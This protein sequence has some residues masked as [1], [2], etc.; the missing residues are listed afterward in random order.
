MTACQRLR[1]YNC[2]RKPE[3]NYFQPN[4]PSMNNVEG[5]CLDFLVFFVQKPPGDGD[6]Q[7]M[8][9]LTGGRDDKEHHNH[10]HPPS[11]DLYPEELGNGDSAGATNNNSHN[12]SIFRDT[13]GSSSGGGR[14]HPGGGGGGR[15]GLFAP[16]PQ[17]PSRSP[18]PALHGGS[19]ENSPAAAGG[20]SPMMRRQQ[21]GRSPSPI[22]GLMRRASFPANA[23]P[24]NFL[25]LRGG[26]HGSSR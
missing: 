8:R 7:T 20:A 23:R 10:G 18:S 6:A 11:G 19:L 17:R 9:V 3:P 13:G 2:I 21:A 26:G 15:R 12:S 4:T 14:G 1:A 16:V 25:D 24:W 22:A 5:F